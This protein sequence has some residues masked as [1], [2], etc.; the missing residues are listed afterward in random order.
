MRWREGMKGCFAKIR[1]E[2]RKSA[3]GSK[4]L[5]KRVLYLFDSAPAGYISGYYVG[6]K[7]IYIYIYVDRLSTGSRFGRTWNWNLCSVYQFWEWDVALRIFWKCWR[8]LENKIRNE[9]PLCKWWIMK[10][11]TV[12]S[13]RI[14]FGWFGS[15]RCIIYAELSYCRLLCVAT[16][17]IIFLKK[18]I[19]KR[20]GKNQNEYWLNADILSADS[21]I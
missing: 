4:C 9:I 7:Y 12:A 14:Y 17:N 2:R 6:P 5:W 10:F 13:I 15:S 1:G 20:E 11:F 8:D 18:E 19:K 16:V 21:E 3:A